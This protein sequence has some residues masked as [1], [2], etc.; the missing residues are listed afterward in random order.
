MESTSDSEGFRT[1]EITS[2]EFEGFTSGDIPE[3]FEESFSDDE[4]YTIDTSEDSDMT[5]INSSESSSSS[6]NEIVEVVSEPRRKRARQA[7]VPERVW[8]DQENCPRKYGFKGGNGI[9]NRTLTVNSTPVDLMNVFI[10][11]DLVRTIAEETNRFAVERSDRRLPH[12]Q[13]WMPTNPEEIGAVIAI[14]VL[15]GIVQKP[16]VRSY[17]S[18]DPLLQTPIFSKTMSRDRFSLLLKYLHF[19]P[20]EEEIQNDRLKKIRPVLDTIVDLCKKTYIPDRNISVDE[21]LFKYHGKLGFKTY[22]PSKRAR[23]GFK[24][25]KLCQSSGTCAGYTWNFQVYSGKSAEAKEGPSSSAVVLQLSE[26]LMGQ[27]YNMYMDNWFSS[28]TLFGEL[29]RQQTNVC[30][31]V[32]LIRKDMPKDMNV[33]LKNGEIDRRTDGN[34]LMVLLWKDKKLVKM[35]TTKHTSSMEELPKR[36]R[37][38]VI[39]AKPS[40][41][42][43]YNQGM[44]GVDRSDQLAASHRSVRKFIKWYKKLFLYFFDMCLVNA[45]C[46]YK[47]LHRGDENPKIKTLLQFKIEWVRKTLNDAKDHLQPLRAQPGRCLPVR[48]R[49]DQHFLVYHAPT[50]KKQIPSKQCVLCAQQET[51]KARSRGRKGR[52]RE[53]RFKCKICQVSLCVVPC[54]E[55]YHTAQ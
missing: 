49:G 48:V 53:S 32:R 45:H 36:N 18:N 52:R 20:K 15:M 55:R 22:N 43:D 35:L 2:T 50:E 31:T 26:P 5:P 7:Q 1:E 38:D 30:G 13:A 9:K 41:V 6:D 46:L 51:T 44:G 39:V 8:T 24:V 17:W 10:T 54:F 27:G 19:V 47:E 16:S 25:Y 33:R 23:F 42:V 37:P 14:A 3:E 21:S 40:C 28:P 12:Q 11:P 29:H 4:S 34:G